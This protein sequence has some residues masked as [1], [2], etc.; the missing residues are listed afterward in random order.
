MRI[1]LA[2]INPIV[3]DVAG[4]TA[5]LLDAIEQA[6]QSRADLLISPEL[7][8][9]GYPPRDLLLRE[10]TIEACE[11]AL[12]E[13][14][15]AVGTDLHAI[16]GLPR[17]VRGGLRGLRNSA[18]VCHNGEIIAFADKQLLPGYDVFDE[19]R[20]FDPG[21]QTLILEI[22]GRRTAILI[23][24]DLWHADDVSARARYPH[25][26]AADLAGRCDVLIS[27]SASPFIIGK[28]DRHIAQLREHATRLSVPILSVNQV[29]ANDDLIFDGR[30][31][32][33]SERG[34][35]IA[36]LPGFVS[37]FE[38]I[39]LTELQEAVQT[40][41][42]PMR[43]VFD[44]IVLAVRDYFLKTGAERAIIGL[45][46]GIDSALTAVIAAAA[47]SPQQ[48]LGVIMPS[49][50]S[51]P[52]SIEDA[53]A[54]VANLNLP[55][56]IVLPIH[57]AHDVM[58]GAVADALGDI[59]GTLA[60][61]N[62]QARLR[63]L[64]LMTISNATPR[65]L[66]LSTSNKSE[67]ATGYSTLYGDMCGA[68]TPLGDLLKTRVYELSNWINTNH[69]ALGFNG[70]P[71]PQPSI[72]K[73]PSAELRPNQTDQDSLPPY[74]ILDAIVERTI[75][76][77]QSPDTIIREA[78]VDAQLVRKY[79]GMIDAA[80]YKREQAAIIPKLTART[81]G[82]GRVMPIVM[83]PSQ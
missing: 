6:R 22:A 64:L 32:V 2:Q 14:A 72:D 78:R 76:R 36:A 18:A 12:R 71:I 26:P 79:T 69:H 70:P 51:S 8:L 81:F 52:G 34:E 33:V 43:E 58:K 7:A 54:L 21:E 83:K 40:P 65:S 27:L 9:I 13:I 46:G 63:G 28:F 48:V 1:A 73:V 56:P 50:Y 66:L 37:A 38:T 77:E 23:C 74:D 10:G 39:D 57:L 60:D 53:N 31:V 61:E 11:N 68:I 35:V 55:A 80:Q 19:D 17:R 59:T 30:S 4:N 47:L 62:T 5:L 42:E 45:S 44:A 82:R 49:Q 16:I 75:D 25:E 24:E 29:G 67:I 20:Y 41:T 3:G 15:R